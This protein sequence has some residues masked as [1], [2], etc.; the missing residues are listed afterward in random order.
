[1]AT[2]LDP[3]VEMTGIS[4]SFPGVRALDGVDFRLF[5]GEVH[6]IVGENGAGKS[7][8]IKILTGVY[9]PESGD[10]RLGGH[11]LVLGSPAEAQDAGIS[12]V[13]QEVNLLPN[14]SV[15]ENIMLGR[16]PRRFGAIDWRAT[17]RR[18][19]EV[20]A[21]LNLDID[22]A[23]TLGDHS[24]AVQQLVAICRAIGVQSRILILDE[25]TS[26]LDAD[27][28]AELFRVIRSLKTA[29]VAIL[30]V[31]HFLD[32]VY[33]ISDRLT[34]LRN[35]ELVGEYETPDILRIELVHKMLGRDFSEFGQV[36]RKLRATLDDDELVPLL[37]ADGLGR[38][39]TISPFDL[40]IYEGEVLGLAG[41]LG[42][43]RTELARLLAGADRADRG[44]LLLNGATISL[45]TPRGA[46]KHRI[47]YSSENRRTEGTIDEL[48]IRENIILALQA[49][50]GWLR[51]IP[52]KRQDELAASYIEALSIRPS[53]AETPAG[54]LS[55][56]NQQRV[57][58]ARWL[59]IAPR[60]LILDEPTRGIDVGAKA[61][62]QRLVLELADNG[63]SVVYIS[64]EL[65]E[66][67]RLADRVVVMRDR[68]KVSDV[69]ND[70]V[71][72]AQVMTLIASGAES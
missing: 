27:E 51:P 67:L 42:S 48:T 36:D 15:A 43:G 57:L 23:S 60:L 41:L 69:E 26:S 70:G 71:T 56:G 10:I 3:V 31:S 1:V 24:L 9:P 35:G 25:P 63:M 6:S 4:Y 29:G 38:R 47:A 12:A 5:P 52:R 16:E 44:I 49:D 7:T 66:V 19:A 68:E 45:R 18:A 46:V 22:P 54:N 37:E 8:L 20:L 59:A 61:E 64:A 39:G 65:E 55:G 53:D 17:R 13:Y 30:F 21:G 62:V 50:R 40:K 14:L 58:L 34:V 33:E 72:F 32:Q 28:V 2:R 11:R